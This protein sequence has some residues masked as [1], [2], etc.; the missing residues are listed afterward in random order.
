MFVT[1]VGLYHRPLGIMLRIAA[2][3]RQRIRKS[4]LAVM[5]PGTRLIASVSLGDV[6]GENENGIEA[7]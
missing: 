1:I 3:K 5:S 2:M 6:P 7:T 4:L